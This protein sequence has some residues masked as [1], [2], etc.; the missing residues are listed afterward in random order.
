MSSD[1][2][3]ARCQ[4]ARKRHPA[5]DDDG[6]L[7]DFVVPAP[8]PEPA[9][10][11]HVKREAGQRWRYEHKSD[12][13]IEFVLG[14]R[15]V[16]N[17]GWQ[18]AESF[19][20]GLMDSAWTNPDVV[21]TLLAPAPAAIP[22][23]PKAIE[24]DQPDIVQAAKERWAERNGQP[25]PAKPAPVEQA[26]CSQR[27]GVHS[28]PVLVRFVEKDRPQP[29]CERCYLYFEAIGAKSDN[30]LRDDKV[31]ERLTRAKLSHVAG[32]HDDDFGGAVSKRAC[33]ELAAFIAAEQRIAAAK[34]KPLADGEVQCHAVSD[35]SFGGTCCLL[36]DGHE[37]A[38]D[39][40]DPILGIV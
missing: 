6:D 38:H 4:Y 8:P 10:P 19:A 16:K 20:C 15:L 14:D 33:Q 30:V 39:F 36:T 29:W 17:D 31:P 12:V 22:A 9:K 32:V 1:D 11:Q 13:A 21:M 18:D 34:I 2:K 23:A 27:N 37:G 25:K 7:H 5:Y 26:T 3:C 28:G 24:A 35:S 40:A